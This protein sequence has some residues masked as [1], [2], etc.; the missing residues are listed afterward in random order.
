MN[1]KITFQKNIHLF[2]QFVKISL[3]FLITW[4]LLGCG[5]RINEDQQRLIQK[6]NAEKESLNKDERD[7]RESSEP[8][9]E[10]D[11]LLHFDDAR[12]AH[13]RGDYSEAINLFTKCIKLKPEFADGWGWRGL[14]K[15]KSGNTQGACEDWNKAIQL[16]ASNFQGPLN[17]NCI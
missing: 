3:L 15:L 7:S 5:N 16:G 4:G 1:K 17:D 11:Y 8:N 14:S 9:N 6:K 12:L 2:T 10:K 13:N